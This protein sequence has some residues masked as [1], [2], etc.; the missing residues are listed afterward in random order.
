MD[1]NASGISRIVQGAGS[2]VDLI[3]Q[4]SSAILMSRSDIYS[5]LDYIDVH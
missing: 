2:L 3:E 1:M 4:S 5:P